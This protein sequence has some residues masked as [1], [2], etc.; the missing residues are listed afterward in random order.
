M[1][2]S[3]LLFAQNDSAKTLFGLNLNDPND[4]T[5]FI[6]N[7]SLDAVNSEFYVKIDPV[8]FDRILLNKGQGFAC[9]VNYPNANRFTEIYNEIVKFYG[10]ENEIKDIIPRSIT[11][12]D[13]V[14]IALQIIEGN[15]EIKRYWFEEKF[16]IKLQYTKK[17]LEVFIGVF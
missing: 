13:I 2:A 1:A 15:A 17:N 5:G 12:G 9:T 14:D 3:C 16:N 6:F 11:D 8:F 10:Y 4:T 7:N